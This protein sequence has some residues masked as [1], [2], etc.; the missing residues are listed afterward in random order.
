MF[1]TNHPRSSFAWGLSPLTG[2][3]IAQLV[4]NP[5][6]FDESDFPLQDHLYSSPLCDLQN[7]NL[8]PLTRVTNLPDCAAYA[9]LEPA[10]LLASRILLECWDTFRSVAAGGEK[11]QVLTTVRRYL[12]T[13]G[14]DAE[15]TLERPLEIR[16]KCEEDYVSI[17]RELLDVLMQPT[18]QQSQRL[19]VLVFIGIQLCSKVLTVA[20]YRSAELLN[21]QRCADLD[22]PSDD[23]WDPDEW[24]YAIQGGSITPIC[25]DNKLSQI[26]GLALNR[27]GAEAMKLDSEHQR[28][29]LT[30]D[31]WAAALEQPLWP[32]PSKRVR[33]PVLQTD[34]WWLDPYG[35][36]LL[37]LNDYRAWAQRNVYAGGYHNKSFT[38]M[39][40]GIVAWSL[41]VG[42]EEPEEE[43]E[44]EDWGFDRDIWNSSDE[45]VSEGRS[46][47]DIHAHH[48]G[49]EK[50]VRAN[51]KKNGDAEKKGFSGVLRQLFAALRT[52]R[53]QKD[54]RTPRSTSR[55]RNYSCF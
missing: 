49:G 44:S 17:D 51:S 42:D 19:A 45:D 33:M 55:Q 31:H 6:G 50:V 3:E 54:T 21:R 28:R 41:A 25:L 37:G 35:K 29:L 4:S 10:F 48:R 36:P 24:E 46:R 52:K 13:V 23:T 20:A 47:E 26:R 16:Y 14:L 40:W 27:R 30:E 43:A 8:F 32:P 34:T 12:P 1:P 11:E 22:D 53:R 9:L 39:D 18:T 2:A 5:A 38:T 15:D 7:E